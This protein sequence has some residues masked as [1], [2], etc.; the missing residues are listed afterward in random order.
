MKFFFRYLPIVL[1]AALLTACAPT[2]VQ[3]A[4]QP[5]VTP[6]DCGCD[7]SDLLATPTGGLAAPGPVGPPAGTDV[8]DELAAY[9][10]QWKTYADQEHGFSFE[11]PAVYESPDFA[12]CAARANE[13]PP[14]GSQFALSLGSRTNL[15]LR[16][17]AD[18]DLQAVV[19]A[20]Q[21]D[22]AH[23]GYQYDAPIERTV[24]G[25]PA[26]VLPYRS[27]GTNRYAEAVFFISEG[28]LYQIDTGTP[29]AC[30]VAAID[31]QEL[32]AY[33]HMLDTF[34]FAK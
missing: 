31:L 22:P 25:S 20:F 33:G 30:D 27:G 13:A 32:E 18:Q 17:A 34:L 8:P 1:L 16:E 19:K 12:F 29:S 14:E 11:Y 2:A 15:T 3:N 24:G 26:L 7:V 10:G 28:T 5:T 23:Q 9:I 4:V 6:T 21:D